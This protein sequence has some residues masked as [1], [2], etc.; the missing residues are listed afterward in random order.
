MQKS[1]EPAWRIPRYSADPIVRCRQLEAEPLP[2]SNASLLDEAAAEVP[3]RLAWRFIDS[4]EVAT[5]AEVRAMVNRIASSLHRLGVRKGT[6][7]AMMVPNVPQ[8]PVTWLA[9]GRLG[10][11]MVPVNISYTA[12]ELDYILNDGA[13]SF[14]VIAEE[15]LDVRGNGT[16]SRRAGGQAGDRRRRD[17]GRPS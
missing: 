16:A 5:Y 17:P 7:V 11:V 3:D 15:F 6:H 2:A 8:F 1:I 10:A 9:L 14:L 13:V 12:R 4:G